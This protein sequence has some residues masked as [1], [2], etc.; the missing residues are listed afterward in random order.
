MQKTILIIEDDIFI[1]DIIARKFSENNFK[2]LV[3]KNSEQ[4]DTVLEKV[5]P[6]LIL[7][8]IILPKVDG[9]EILKKL[10]ADKKLMSIPVVIFSNL[11]EE[12]DI[13]K[14]RDLGAMDYLVKA[15]LFPEEVVEKITKF[16]SK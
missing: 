4:A 11:G 16:L 1:L 13:K 3:A 2:V 6:N 9:F 15:N 7:L 12:K 14:A 5:I 10:K 8:D